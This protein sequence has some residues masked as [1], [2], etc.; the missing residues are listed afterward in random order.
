[1]KSEVTAYLFPFYI[2]TM[3]VLTMLLSCMAIITVSVFLLPFEL[4]YV[5]CKGNIIYRFH[6]QLSCF[7]CYW[8]IS[9][10]GKGYFM[11]A[12]K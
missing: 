5:P 12:L 3:D 10:E 8:V 1:M 11:D 9:H 7:Y 6:Q 4:P 2:Q